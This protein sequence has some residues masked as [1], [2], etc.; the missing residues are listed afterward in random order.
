MIEGGIILI[1]GDMIVNDRGRT[2]RGNDRG[3]ND[4][5]KILIEGGRIE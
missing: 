2:D 4:G 1:Q 5:G 3:S